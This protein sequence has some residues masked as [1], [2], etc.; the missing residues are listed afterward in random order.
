MGFE[1]TQHL[2]LGVTIPWNEFNA[3]PEGVREALN[4]E[5]RD[6]P[7]GVGVLPFGDAP[8]VVIFAKG[9]GDQWVDREDG[10][11]VVEV[12]PHPSDTVQILEHFQMVTAGATTLAKY[13]QSVGLDAGFPRWLFVQR[14][15]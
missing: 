9:A 2:V 15:W 14:Y 10:N 4:G 5:E 3:L 13:C 12:G 1:V 8:D 6:W 11:C 7:E